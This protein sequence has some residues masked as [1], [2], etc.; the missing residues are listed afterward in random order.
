[1]PACMPACIRALLFGSQRQMGAK[2]H[3][4]FGSE[5]RWGRALEPNPWGPRPNGV[6][7]QVPVPVLKG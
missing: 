3:F 1:M 6:P 5:A 4:W 2:W 7:V